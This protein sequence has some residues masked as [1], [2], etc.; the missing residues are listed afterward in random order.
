MAGDWTVVEFSEVL[1]NG[2][3]NGVYKPKEFHGSG[4]KIVNMGEL[5]AYPRLHDVPMNRLELAD[6]EL[7]KAS[8]QPGDLLFARRSLVAEGADKCSIVMELTE[9]TTFESSII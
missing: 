3:R 4:V 8:L 7:E 5:F 1:V 6:T 9:P 2:T